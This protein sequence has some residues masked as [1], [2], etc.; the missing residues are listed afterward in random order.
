M[1]STFHCGHLQFA[2]LG[3]LHG[4]LGSIPGLLVEVLDLIDDLVALEDF[5]EDDVAAIEPAR[6]LKLF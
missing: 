3:D 4:L 5:A 1:A 2:A 6:K